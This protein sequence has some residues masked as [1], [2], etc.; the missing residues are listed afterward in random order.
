MTVFP[1]FRVAHEATQRHVISDVEGE[2]GE[3]GR[4]GE[5]E[6][7]GEGRGGRGGRQST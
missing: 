3:G 7:E 2:A 4:E 6:R 1:V 5:R